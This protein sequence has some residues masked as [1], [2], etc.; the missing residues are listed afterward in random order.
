MHEGFPI[1][2]VEE[3]ALITNE[4]PVFTMKKD[5]KAKKGGKKKWFYCIDLHTT[6]K[7]LC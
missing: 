4:E 3:D 5:D 6:V 7:L 2:T 1:R